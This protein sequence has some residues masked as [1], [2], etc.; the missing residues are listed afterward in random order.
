MTPTTA[1]LTPSDLPLHARIEIA[2]EGGAFRACYYLR[3]PWGD[4]SYQAGTGHGPTMD[5]AA[6]DAIANAVDPEW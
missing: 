2:P 1:P 4:L 5:A 3:G 6:R